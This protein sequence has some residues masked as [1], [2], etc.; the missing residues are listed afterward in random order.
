MAGLMLNNV[1]VKEDI[2]A[3]EKYKFLFTVEEV[4]KMVIEGVPFRDAYKKIG[5]DVES[6]NFSYTTQINHTHEG[7]IGNLQNDQVVR[8]MNTVVER[9]NFSKVHH[10]LERLLH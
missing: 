6:G 2:L 7:S 10:A 5:Q 1:Q 4:N 9:F 3:D 8:K